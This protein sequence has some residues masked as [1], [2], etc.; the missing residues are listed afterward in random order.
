MDSEEAV[1][2]LRLADESSMLDRAGRLAD[3]VDLLGG[4]SANF[5]GDEAEVLFDDV[6]ATWIAGYLAATIVS[7]HAFCSFQLA[8]LLRMRTDLF[9]LER[10]TVLSLEDL[11]RHARDRGLI[12]VAAHGLCVELEERNR[13]FVDAQ[14][15]T[16]DRRYNRHLDDN[17]EF[18]GEHSLLTGA[19]V[20]L[21]ASI[22]VAQ[23]G[24]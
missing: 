24:L 19:R 15:A 21:S 3:L 8:S 10:E 4:A 20:A 14:T 6:Q 9:Q 17:A 16:R 12:D 13:D 1:A 18:E 11:A 22:A 5:Q 23:A 7:A 2:A